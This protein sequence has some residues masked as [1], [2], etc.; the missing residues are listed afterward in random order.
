[1]L[2]FIT[3]NHEEEAQININLMNIIEE[4]ILI[5]GGNFF[6]HTK[7]DYKATPQD[8]STTYLITSVNI[9]M[10]KC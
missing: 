1:M 6:F 9:W 10:H 2:I 3:N 5:W 4:S 7:F 8:I